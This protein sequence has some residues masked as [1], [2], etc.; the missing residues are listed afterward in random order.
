[1]KLRLSFLVFIFSLTTVQIAAGAGMRPER[2]EKG[3]VVS[4]HG[5][6]S[7]AG[8]EM[9][10]AGGNAIDAAVATGFALAV[11]HPTAGNIG[12]GGF[13]LVRLNDGTT[14]FIDYREKAPGKASEKMYQDAQG[15]IVPNLSRVGYKAVG[16]PG[17]VKGL[18]HAQKRYGKLT[19]AQVMAPAIRL[20][21]DGFTLDY[22][23]AR[24]LTEDKGLA[25]F[26]DSKR[27]FQNGGKGWKQG[28]VF[29]QPE[30]ARTLERIV[31]SPDDFYTGKMAREFAEF[32]QAGG[33][34]ITAQDLANYDVKDRK[35]VTGTYRGLDVISAPPPSSGGIAL[36]ETLNILEGFDLAKAG[37]GSAESIHLITEAYRR[38]FYDRAQFLGD[39]EFSELPVMELA[40]KKYAVEWRQSV[41]PA[42]ASPSQKI[43]R[44]KT[45]TKLERYV[46][47]HPVFVP[48]F[49][50]TQTT[51]YSVVDAEGNAVAVTTT[52]NGGYGS[53]VTAGSLGFL[54]NNEMDDFSSKPGAPNM[55]GL[56]QGQENAIGPNKRP[57]SAM[58]PTIV[59]K[60]G[61][62]WLVLG[63]PGGPTIITTV[64][65]ILVGVADFGLDIQQA[66]NA[67]RFHHQ[68]VPDRIMLERN[69]FSPDTIKLLEGRGHAISFGGVGDGECIQI[70]LATG[71]RLGAS[72]GRNESGKAVG[73]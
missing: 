40:D 34:L 44:P 17:S 69:R 56:I 65:N 45:S 22:G 2:A 48:G 73:Y 9:M 63:S 19:L 20:A 7:E 13:M 36:I 27:I 54:L 50:P 41:D 16:V 70:D 72:D 25:Q 47:E 57:L 4:V 18:V 38:A 6:A 28:D 30:L 51:H 61:K 64:T 58:T 3:M 53:K 14:N 66:V 35:P 59:L 67:P 31:S 39:P 71:M 10:K 68:W 46:K 52:L 8:V 11:V 29:K 15:N 33:G 5:L 21:R 12:G 1:M 62:L 60:D 32:M 26:A 55:F 24:S 23:D 37:F 49:E 43:V 42:H